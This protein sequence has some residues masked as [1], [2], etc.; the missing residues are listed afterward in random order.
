M[1]SD[2]VN[3]VF[4]VKLMLGMGKGYRKKS[5]ASSRLLF[6]THAKYLYLILYNIIYYSVA[7]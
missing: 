3:L 2:G 5:I 4:E 7:G 1:N 6:P